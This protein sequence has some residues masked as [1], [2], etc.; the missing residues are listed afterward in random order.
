MVSRIT[1]GPRKICFIC[2]LTSNISVKCE[3]RST[4]P[5]TTRYETTQAPLIFQAASV[6]RA[7]RGEQKMCRIRCIPT[8]CGPLRNAG[9]LNGR[10]LVYRENVLREVYVAYGV[11]Q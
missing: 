5:C 7:I 2:C 4:M 8:D 6:R 11:N 10:E 1:L 3:E 9:E